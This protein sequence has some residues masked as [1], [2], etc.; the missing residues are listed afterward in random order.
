MDLYKS[1]SQLLHLSELIKEKPNVKRHTEHCQTAQR[2]RLRQ[3][4]AQLLDNALM[5]FPHYKSILN[6]MCNRREFEDKC[7]RL[8]QQERQPWPDA[9]DGHGSRPFKY[10]VGDVVRIKGTSLIFIFVCS[11]VLARIYTHAFADELAVITFYHR[12]EDDGA[13][14]PTYDVLLADGL[15]SFSSSK[16]CTSY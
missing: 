8:C 15:R 6:A 14:E 4:A 3:I 10:R 7:R 1:Q 12:P 5:R 2:L 13:S 9:Y 16:N 11:S